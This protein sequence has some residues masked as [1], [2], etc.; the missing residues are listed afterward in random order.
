MTTVART[1]EFADVEQNNSRELTPT[2]R[3][4]DLPEYVFSWLDA[5]KA[6]ARRR[7]ADLI[8]L[9]M[10]NPDQPTPAPIIDAIAA[11]FHDSR[12]HGYPPFRG[13]PPFRFPQF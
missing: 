2:R 5:L 9:G 1:G 13:T 12:T 11:A 4:T 3:L 10:G 6:D 7:G 8:D